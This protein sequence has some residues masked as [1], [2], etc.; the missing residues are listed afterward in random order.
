[1]CLAAPDED[2]VVRGSVRLHQSKARPFEVYAVLADQQICR[3]RFRPTLGQ[4][5]VFARGMI[6]A[7]I[8][9]DLTVGLYQV[10]ATRT[11]VLQ[12]FLYSEYRLLQNGVV[13]MQTGVC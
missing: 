1:M 3:L 10:V 13:E 6:A 7:V 12:R 4:I 5:L 2:V 9:E 8:N 11:G